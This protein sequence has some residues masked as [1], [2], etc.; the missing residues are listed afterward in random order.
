MQV[1]YVPE[2]FE[3]SNLQVFPHTDIELAELPKRAPAIPLPD[4]VQSQPPAKEHGA[5]AR[6]PPL[7]VRGLLKVKTPEQAVSSTEV[8]LFLKM[9]ETLVAVLAAGTPV[10]KVQ[11]TALAA[12]KTPVPLAPQKMQNT[13][14]EAMAGNKD[15]VKLITSELDRLTAES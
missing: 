15:P 3:T 4:T 8:D 11:S 12:V 13:S 2:D 5:E 1:A 6:E 10:V 9:R 7:M 14:F